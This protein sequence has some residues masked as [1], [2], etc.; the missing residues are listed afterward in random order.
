MMLMKDM[1]TGHF[2]SVLLLLGFGLCFERPRQLRVPCREGEGL[3]HTAPAGLPGT[4]IDDQSQQQTRMV[5][6]QTWL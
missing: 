4:P 5:P 6:P 1:N 3:L 2:L